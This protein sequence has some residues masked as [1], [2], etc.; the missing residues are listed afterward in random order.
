M[1]MTIFEKALINDYVSL[2]S[3]NYDINM[4]DKSGKTLLHYAVLGDSIDVI[5]YL[6]NNNFNLNLVDKNNESAIFDCARKGKLEI[7]KLLFEKGAV[8][9]FLNNKGESLFHLAFSRK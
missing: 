6:I 1:I 8:L 4:V 3:K 7:A 2:A 5:K 9:N